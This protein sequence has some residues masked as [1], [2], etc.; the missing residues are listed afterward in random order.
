MK[1]DKILVAAVVCVVCL[2]LGALALLDPSGG[3]ST[4]STTTAQLTG[5]SWNVASIRVYGGTNDVA[6]M[7]NMHTNTF[8]TRVTAGSVVF[9]PPDGMWTFVASQEGEITN[10]LWKTTN[11]T[12]S[13]Y[14]GAQ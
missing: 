7:P 11:G 6:F 5:G 2:A 13:V 4:A 10:V 14:V 8:N 12:A 9:V 1:A 3:K